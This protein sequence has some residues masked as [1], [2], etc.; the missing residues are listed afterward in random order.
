MD[1]TV[2][3]EAAAYASLDE[4]GRLVVPTLLDSVQDREGHVVWRPSGLE[5]GCDEPSRPPQIVD[6]RRQIAD[7]QSVFQ[8]VTMMQGV[9]QRGTG[10]PAGAGLNHLIAGKTGTTQDFTDAWF[11]GFTADLVTVVWVGFDNPT[12]LGENQTGAV[13]AA[14]IWHDYMA[15]A[16]KHR[17]A[18]TFPQPSGVT[19]SSWNTGSGTVMDA[20]SRNQ[21]PGASAPIGGGGLIAEAPPGA[22][23]ASDASSGAAGGVDTSLG[24]LY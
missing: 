3:R 18:L 13:V 8:L 4:G 7:P 22:L 5:C 20:L 14:P 24:G 10:V 2:L 12:S 21:A 9:V 15:F 11:A 23:G 6:D 1:T 16:L 19:M 17:P